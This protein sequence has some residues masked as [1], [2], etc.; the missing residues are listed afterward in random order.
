MKK[1]YFV[2]N[3]YSIISFLCLISRGISNNGILV[4]LHSINYNMANQGE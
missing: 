4:Q 2:F 1:G 3:L